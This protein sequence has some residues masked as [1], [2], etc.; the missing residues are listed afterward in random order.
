MKR[1]G[2]LNGK[3]IYIGTDN[4]ANIDGMETSFITL[5]KD[6]GIV[7]IRHTEYFQ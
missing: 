5:I 3:T 2:T 7:S 6:E 1:I 4:D